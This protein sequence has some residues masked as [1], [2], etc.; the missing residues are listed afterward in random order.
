MCYFVLPIILL[1]CKYFPIVAIFFSFSLN[2]TIFLAYISQYF[3]NFQIFRTFFTL[4]LPI[5][6]HSG[7][8]LFSL[9]LSLF[10]RRCIHLLLYT[11]LYIR[12]RQHLYFCMHAYYFSLVLRVNAHLFLFL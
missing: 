6:P 1:F 12:P 2:F 5:F 10:W 7:A 8:L 11:R 3:A 4:N 9:L